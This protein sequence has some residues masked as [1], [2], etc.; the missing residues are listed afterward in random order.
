[1]H[2][3]KQ[4]HRGWFRKHFGLSRTLGRQRGFT[5]TELMVTCAIL[6]VMVTIASIAYASGTRKTEVVAATE[7][8]KQVFRYA[9]S[10]TDSGQ[11]SG[12]LKRC[13]RITFHNNGESP[14][15][16][17]LIEWST[18]PVGFSSPTELVPR[19]SQAFKLVGNWIQLGTPDIQ[20]T[21]SP[22]QVTY[23]T[24]GSIVETL[25]VGTDKSVTVGSSSDGSNR[26]ISINAWGTINE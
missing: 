26:T 16:A 6:A 1:M 2:T 13:Y 20:M 24:R 19:K 18:D 11:T 23:V 7:Q 5:M 8:V 4:G 17:C 25:P 3:S 12:G 21:Y 15:N 22:S 14:P 10:L 9:Y